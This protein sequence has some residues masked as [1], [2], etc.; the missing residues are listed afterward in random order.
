MLFDNPNSYKWE[1]DPQRESGGR[2]VSLTYEQWS[3]EDNISWLGQMVSYAVLYVDG[4]L[5]MSPDRRLVL[6]ELRRDRTELRVLEKRY[7]ELKNI[8]DIKIEMAQIHEKIIKLKQKVY[9]LEINNISVKDLRK[10]ISRVPDNGKLQVKDNKYK[11]WR[12]LN[13]D[14]IR[15]LMGQEWGK[16]SI[17]VLEP[18]PEEELK[19]EKI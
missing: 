3:D 8:K 14:E 16:G 19:K 17:Q 13:Y 11:S 5:G 1:P 4:P 18:V 12:N 9:K 7:M 15:V 6:A 10:L 2:V